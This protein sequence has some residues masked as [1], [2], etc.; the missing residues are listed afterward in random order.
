ML[1]RQRRALA[2]W[3]LNG[4]CSPEETEPFHGKFYFALSFLPSVLYIQS[5]LA[6]G[7]SFLTFSLISFCADFMPVCWKAVLRITSRDLRILFIESDL[8]VMVEYPRVR[9]KVLKVGLRVFYILFNFYSCCVV[10]NLSSP[11]RKSGLCSLASRS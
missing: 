7:H 1:P 11:E 6:C 3:I 10:R 8:C 9:G 2:S 5:F 4:F